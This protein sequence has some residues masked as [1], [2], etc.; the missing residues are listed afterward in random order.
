[1]TARLEKIANVLIDHGDDLDADVVRELVATM[2]AERAKGTAKT[3]SPEDLPVAGPAPKAEKPKLSV[4][5]TPREP[6]QSW[7]EM[8]YFSALD[9]KKDYI[10]EGDSEM[11]NQ[12]DSW[13]RKWESTRGM[14]PS[15]PPLYLQQSSPQ[16]PMIPSA[17][18][19]PG[20]DP[21]ASKMRQAQQMKELET[22]GVILPK[23]DP[24]LDNLSKLKDDR[25][26][27]PSEYSNKESQSYGLMDMLPM[28]VGG[29]A[30]SWNEPTLEDFRTE[31]RAEYGDGVDAWDESSGAYRKYAD[32]EW[33]RAYDNAV[34]NKRPIYRQ[35]VKMQQFQTPGWGALPNPAGILEGMK[36]NKGG[37][38]RTLAQEGLDASVAAAGA[39]DD[40]AMFGAAKGATRLLGNPDAADAMEATQKRSQVGA[41][42]GGTVGAFAPSAGANRVAGG[43]YNVLKRA[44]PESALMRTAAAS[45]AGAAGSAAQDV[46]ER[47]VREFTGA[48]TRPETDAVRTML[49][50]GLLGGTLHAGGEGIDRMVRSRRGLAS[51]REMISDAG[52][53]MRDADRYGIEPSLIG[54]PK[55]P[56]GVAELRREAA[57]AGRAPAELQ[58]DKMLPRMKSAALE[59][60][61]AHDKAPGAQ[62]LEA[63]FNSPEGLKKV[64]VKPVTDTAEA[65]LKDLVNP[66]TGRP[67]P[68]VDEAD[69]RNLKDFVG[70]LYSLQSGGATALNARQLHATIEGLR[71]RFN[72]VPGQ[73][74]VLSSRGQR[75]VGELEH[76]LLKVR[77]QFKGGTELTYRVAD[78]TEVGGLSALEHQ[79]ASEHQRLA[80]F[81]E[82][83]GLPKDKLTQQAALIPQGKVAIP[84]VELRHAWDEGGEAALPPVQVFEDQG[85]RTLIQGKG[86]L[87]QAV[88]EGQESIPATVVKGASPMRPDETRGTDLRLSQ[89]DQEGLFPQPRMSG[90]EAGKFKETLM[91]YKRMDARSPERDAALQSLA[92]MAGHEKELEGLAANTAAENLD[93]FL[94]QGTA[95]SV[96]VGQFGIGGFMR[97]KA[98]NVGI[99]TDPL[100]R[101]LAAEPQTPISDRLLEFVKTLRKQG[102]KAAARQQAGHG[103]PK[104]APFEGLPLRGGQA[105][106]RAEQMLTDED[107]LNLKSLLGL[108][109]GKDD[110]NSR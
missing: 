12:A 56:Q 89:V 25:Y 92:Q 61:L 105:G 30:E 76:S 10:A 74:P 31:K 44:A 3:Y 107:I 40:N 43:V 87:K 20:E 96:D 81:K 93:R 80:D 19:L 71:E 106:A 41:A 68:D 102:P 99:R 73:R 47:T 17:S 70:R 5:I 42:I 108:Y 54:S 13:I 104:L 65:M 95:S 62:A 34:A 11:A 24:S 66:D 26:Y 48:D 35:A 51:G 67:F 59:A 85:G 90:K 88:K 7:S 21:V 45:A 6:W 22:Q 55:V 86:R 28:V 37:A 63:Y 29:K 2:K 46:G 36:S 91:A 94:R 103:R 53:V 23:E 77:D 15:G 39:F 57:S 69:I 97:T 32:E 79:R 72:L 60:E 9:A 101:R 16:T 38:L 4:E 83:A 52:Q 84:P 100:Q 109:Q 64:S 1:M 110:G 50:G 58:A 14:L 27:R 82:S 78:G 18:P 98:Q 49:L 75:I 8:D 33:A